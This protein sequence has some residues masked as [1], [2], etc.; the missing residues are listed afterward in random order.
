MV[1]TGTQRT[2]ILDWHPPGTVKGER[3]SDDETETI[4]IES[5]RTVTKLHRDTS[6]ASRLRCGGGVRIIRK[7]IGS[8]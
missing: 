2:L 8:H 7:A 5:N 1:T 4:C 6:D 3:V